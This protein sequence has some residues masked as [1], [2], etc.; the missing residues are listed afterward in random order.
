VTLE[1]LR[2]LKIPPAAALRR[3]VYL[4]GPA[5]GGTSIISES[6]GLHPKALALTSNHFLDDVWRYRNKIHWR[7]W[8]GIFHRPRF[9][10]YKEIVRS[11][12]ESQ[13]QALRRYVNESLKLKEF[14]R[15]YQL[16]PLLHALDASCDKEPSALACWCDK[17]TNWRGLG[18]IKRG[19]PE[20]R[21][22]FIARDPRSVVLSQVR[23]SETKELVEASDGL[24]AAQ[25]IKAALHWRVM[26]LTLR[27][28]AR[29]NPDSATW[30]RYEDFVA[31]PAETLQRLHAFAIGETMADDD[32]ARALERISG[33]ATNDP[34]RYSGISA[35][36]VERWR[37]RLGERERQL[38]AEIT[39]GTAE[40]LGYQLEHP[41]TRAGLA[42][43]LA[44]TPG[45]KERV[46]T[47]LKLAV[48]SLLERLG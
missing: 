32:L 25:V 10:D 16:Y 20:A 46:K 39:G 37:S 2:G 29:Q 34:D 40:A 43:I 36:P 26:M 14:A 33:G 44:S 23:R 45:G 6:L 22:I 1:D 18:L 15:L 42:G 13:G 27:R 24:D 28:F 7:L 4:V 5:R 8:S 38:I 35:A 48:A 19:F 12:P 21:F 47:G 11:L 41:G 30:V 9:F 17:S 31:A 3:L